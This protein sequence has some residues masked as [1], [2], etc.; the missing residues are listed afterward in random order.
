MRKKQ[1]II[2]LIAALSIVLTVSFVMVQMGST[3]Q[4]GGRASAPPTA[5]SA[6]SQN[7]QSRPDNSAKEERE[8]PATRDSA[9][10]EVTRSD[11]PVSRG[12][13]R[14]RGRESASTDTSTQVA[15]IGVVAVS[16]QTYRAK[17]K[18]YGVVQPKYN[19][20]FVSQVS[21]QVVSISEQFETGQQV[22]KGQSLGVIDPIDYQAALASAQANYDEALVALEEEK[23]QGQQAQDE[24]SRSGLSGEPDSPLVL[25]SPQ[26][27]SAT[28]ALK[29]AEESLA[30]A[31][32]DLAASKLAVPFNALVVSREVSPGSIVQSGGEVATLYST[33]TAEIAVALSPSQWQ[34]LPAL[35][36]S[37]AMGW[38]VT[39]TDTNNTSQ[40][41]AKVE[42]VE[43][44]QDETT[45]QRN[46]IVVISRPLAQAAPLHFGSFV[47]AYIDGRE[48]QDVWRIPSTAI[49]QQQ[50]VWYVRQDTNQLAKFTP[51]VLFEYEGYAY[52]SPYGALRDALIVV[53]PLSSYIE[54]TKVSPVIE[55]GQL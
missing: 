12:M 31:K 17:V 9:P 27:T 48:L 21:G 22:A 33:D 50:E 30:Q 11:N 45:R 3:S 52:I 5:A 36:E 43:L 47:T 8:R 51:S 49:S 28:S 55:G 38:P 40:W 46:A 29:D 1:I 10:R 14:G 6:P 34:Q 42:R 18:G 4:A 35:S 20:S 23:L 24:W 16:P 37:G 54:N 32:R 7:P 39:L 44:H 2:T 53:R 41:Q 19:L 25:R 15:Q 26:L 13:G